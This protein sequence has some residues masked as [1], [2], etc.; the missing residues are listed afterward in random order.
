[1][2]R[3]GGRG[4]ALRFHLHPD[5]QASPI[6]GGGSLLLK[7]PGGQGWRFRCSDGEP[8]LADSVYL[9]RAGEMRRAHQIVLGG[10]VPDDGR[11]EVKWAFRKV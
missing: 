9:G 6:H 3:A 10:I 2:A 11:Q 4:Y 5:V 8:Q 1:M 7:L